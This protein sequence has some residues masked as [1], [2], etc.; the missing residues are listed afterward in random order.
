[1]KRPFLQGTKSLSYGKSPLAMLKNSFKSD[2]SLYLLITPVI[3]FFIIFHYWPMLGVQIA[4]KDF[5]PMKGIWDS[6]WVGFKHFARFFNSF[7][8]WRLM[9]NT[10]GINFYQLIVGFPIP[11]L[12]A[13]MLNEVKSKYFKK[14]VQMATYAPHFLSMVVLVGMVMVASLSPE[15]NYKSAYKIGRRRTYTLY[16]RSLMV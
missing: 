14:L 4:F 11:I 8:F 5:M 12:L 2:W 13:L 10:L 6:P 3:I 16:D 1:M 9:K 15:R 7:Q